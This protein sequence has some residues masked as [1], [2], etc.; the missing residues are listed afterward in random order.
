[1][2]GIFSDIKEI[3]PYENLRDEQERL[4]YRLCA[5]PNLVVGV[6]TD[7][8]ARRYQELRDIGF[9]FDTLIV[10]QGVSTVDLLSAVHISQKIIKVLAVDCTDR[11]TL[12]KSKLTNCGPVLRYPE[13]SVKHALYID[14]GD[15]KGKGMTENNG[16]IQNVAEAE[17]AIALYMWVKINKH[18]FK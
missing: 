6:T 17:Y 16:S 11:F 9:T 8:L 3:M 5:T 12:E 7:E 15:Y 4:N 2:E 10:D 1:M 14:V 13:S 18:K